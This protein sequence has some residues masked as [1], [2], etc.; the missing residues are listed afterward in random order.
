[1]AAKLPW[2][3]ELC[4]APPPSTPDFDELAAA[5]SAALLN[6]ALGGTAG[7]VV[8]FERICEAVALA[9]P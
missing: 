6:G 7:A 5:P 3:T 9:L 4:S 2:L 8:L 1:L